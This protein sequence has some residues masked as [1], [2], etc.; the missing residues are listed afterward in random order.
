MKEFYTE[1]YFAKEPIEHIKCSDV[2]NLDSYS[3][4][5]VMFEVVASDWRSA[6]KV[7]ADKYPN[8]AY[9]HLHNSKDLE[10]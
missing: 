3:E 2:P 6:K 1:L 8:V 9:I 10:P 4:S 5:T 7:I